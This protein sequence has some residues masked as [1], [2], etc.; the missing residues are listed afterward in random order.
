MFLPLDPV[1]PE[2]RSTLSDFQVTQA[3]TFPFVLV[4]VKFDLSAL[5]NNMQ[6]YSDRI[7]KQC[8]ISQKHHYSIWVGCKLLCCIAMCCKGVGAYTQIVSPQ[9][10]SKAEHLPTPLLFIGNFSPRI[11]FPTLCCYYK[12]SDTSMVRFIKCN[13]STWKFS[14]GD[15]GSLISFPLGLFQKYQESNPRIKNENSHNCLYKC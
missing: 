8:F 7:P 15:Q 5:L 14:I 10:W 12:C 3:N 6:D 2:V 11:T 13:L 1:V 9:K 4:L